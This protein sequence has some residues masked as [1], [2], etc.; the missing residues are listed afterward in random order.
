MHHTGSAPVP[1]LRAH[2]SAPVPIRQITFRL[3]PSVHCV[4]EFFGRKQRGN[5]AIQHEVERLG[6]LRNQALA[7][8]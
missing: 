5:M 3:A 1:I 7:T 6:G 4:S 8:L 2:S